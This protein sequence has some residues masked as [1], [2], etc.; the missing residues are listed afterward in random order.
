VMLLHVLF[1]AAKHHGHVAFG[2]EAHHHVRAFVHHPDVV[3]WIDAHAVT[4]T[5]AVEALA[6][7][8]HELALV[9]ELEQLRGE[10]AEKG[11]LSPERDSMKTCPLE[12][13]ATAA[14]SP[15]FIS[16]GYLK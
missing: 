9:I 11:P 6:D 4:E 7:L 12:F 13:T 3:R 16:A 8:A 2:V 15:R 5:K 1:L 10:G 14:I